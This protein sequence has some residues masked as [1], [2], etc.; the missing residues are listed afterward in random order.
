MSKIKITKEQYNTILLHEQKNRLN[1]NNR[2]INEN[3]KDTPEPLEKGYREAILCVAFML[4]FNLTG[5]NKENVDK[6]I[7]DK[8]IMGQVKSILED[9]EKIKKLVDGLE[10]KGMVDPLN[11]LK[12]KSSNLIKKY[13]E[14]AINNNIEDRLGPKTLLTLK[15]IE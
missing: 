4:G 14:I 6:N 12:E 13:N 3:S 10:A 7:K 15:K 1:D 8:N 2:V 9:E 11:R 5:L